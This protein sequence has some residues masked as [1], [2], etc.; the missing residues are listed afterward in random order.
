MS[1][2]ETVIDRWAD[3]WRHVR[4]CRERYE[5]L[6]LQPGVDVRFVLDAVIARLASRY[7]AG[8]RT[9]QLY[10]QMVSVE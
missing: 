1:G 8:E 10:M 3:A 2:K 9:E 6:A 7:L 5:D 4:E